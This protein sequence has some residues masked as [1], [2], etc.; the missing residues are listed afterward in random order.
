MDALKLALPNIS[1]FPFEEVLR[2]REKANSEL[3]EF[4]N[5]LETFQFNLQE[6]YSLQ[7]IHLKS[8][9]IVKHKLNPKLIDLKSKIENLN[10][11]V[12]KLVLDQFK[13]PKSY[14]PLIGSFFGGIPAHIATLLS[15]G[16]ITFSTAYDYITKR[17]EIK[18]NGLYYL[19]KLD[20]S[21]G[22]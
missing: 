22:K 8:S 10:L 13:D 6:N 19:I 17:N 7:E 3:L 20:Q 21:F 11:S 4:R 9:E 14:S 16:L 12:P 18:K 1:H 15:L 2:V 5:E